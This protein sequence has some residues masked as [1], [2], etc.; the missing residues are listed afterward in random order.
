MSSH[1]SR[2]LYLCRLLS[3]L[4]SF[5][6][7][8]LSTSRFYYKP[9]P[10]FDFLRVDGGRFPDHQPLPTTTNTVYTNNDRNEQ[11]SVWLA[12]LMFY[13]WDRGRE[14]GLGN[15]ERGGKGGGQKGNIQRSYLF[16]PKRT[17]CE[18]KKR[19]GRRQKDAILYE[20]EE[21]KNK[22]GRKQERTGS[23]KETSRRETIGFRHLSLC[24]LCFLF[25]YILV[26]FGLVFSFV[27][28]YRAKSRI[29]RFILQVF[30]VF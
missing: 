14:N 3:F 30:F 11:R 17:C 19:E 27:W 16:R 21:T 28:H 25:C 5:S 23:M 8:P 9:S 4:T 2:S 7:F 12:I 15:T 1:N 6:P 10:L 29:R 18:K 24:L 20:R 13:F 26:M 22:K